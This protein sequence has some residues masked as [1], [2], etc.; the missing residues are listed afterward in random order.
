MPEMRFVIIWPD[1]K[2]MLCYSPSLV[3]KDHLAVGE[4][5]AVADFLA[6]AST[7]LNIASER[8]RKKYAYPCARALSQLAEIENAC[9]HY[10]D[11][12]GKGVQV[13]E[14]IEG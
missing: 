11:A 13:K 6:R 1:G 10:K 8:V 9:R 7:A 12:V 5:Y 2:P 4:S 14:F 3:I